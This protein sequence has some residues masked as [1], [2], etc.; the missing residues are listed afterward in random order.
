MSLN[1]VSNRRSMTGSLPRSI[2]DGREYLKCCYS[3]SSPRNSRSTEYMARPT[4][5]R[6]D[7]ILTYLETEHVG[8]YNWGFVASKTQTIYPWNSWEKPSTDEPSV[9]FHDISQPD[10]SP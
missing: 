5:S 8:A 9:W 7:P 2:R 3:Q 1:R 10:G 6:F 4:G